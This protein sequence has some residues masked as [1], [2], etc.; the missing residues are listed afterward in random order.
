MQHFVTNLLLIL[1]FLCAVDIYSVLKRI[2][3][4]LEKKQ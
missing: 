3:T 2:A 4:A 1:L